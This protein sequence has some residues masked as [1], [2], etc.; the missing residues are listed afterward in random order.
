MA[1]SLGEGSPLTDTSW[2]R[3]RRPDSR[4]SPVSSETFLSLALDKLM[5]LIPP[6]LARGGRA[7]PE[8]E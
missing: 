6:S 7:L 4:P 8:A 5:P 1:W 3:A 2:L